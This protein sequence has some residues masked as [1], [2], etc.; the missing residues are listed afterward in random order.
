MFRPTWHDRLCQNRTMPSVG[1]N[2]ISCPPRKIFNNNYNKPF[3]PSRRLPRAGL[4]LEIILYEDKKKLI[5]L[6]VP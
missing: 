6:K 4:I 2:C 5:L 3:R 1:K